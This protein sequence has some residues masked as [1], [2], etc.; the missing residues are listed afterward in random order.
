MSKIKTN[1]IGPWTKKECTIRGAKL[2]NSLSDLN[3]V[4]KF[5]EG[6]FQFRE[7][8][9]W[10]TLN[11]PI[12][13][14]SNTPLKLVY[15]PGASFPGPRRG[16]AFKSFEALYEVASVFP[17]VKEIMFDNGNLDDLP[18]NIVGADYSSWPN[19]TNACV[20]PPGDYDFKNTMLR[21]L[22][23]GGNFEKAVPMFDLAGTTTNQS[24]S[25]NIPVLIK[26]GV[27]IKNLSSV[28]GLLIIGDFEGYDEPP[29]TYDAL[30]DVK[31]IHSITAPDGSITSFTYFAL[32]LKDCW[33][34]GG[35]GPLGSGG[36]IPGRTRSMFLIDGGGTG[37]DNNAMAISVTQSIFLGNNVFSIAN[38]V[39]LSLQDSFGTSSCF[40]G[41]FTTEHDSVDPTLN[42]VVAFTTL[43]GVFSADHADWGGSPIA[44]PGSILQK[45]DYKPSSGLFQLGAE[46]EGLE[47]A[48]DRMASAIKEIRMVIIAAD[49]GSL[50]PPDGTIP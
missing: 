17:G 20:I 35:G 4:F 33:L 24:I 48:L 40:E 7:D 13:I 42:E 32:S 31:H 1:S 18:K 41:V 38:G 28:L 16:N 27:R 10:K 14:S 12:E 36:L 47:D 8:G 49:P 44:F 43:T 21:S 25:T 30:S 50:S 15:S 2:G 22:Y 3:G 23:D 39:T 37:T 45:I 11:D 26:N 19:E 9:I 5:S 34:L 6:R 29:I 46:P